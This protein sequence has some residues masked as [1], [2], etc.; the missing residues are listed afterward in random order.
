MYGTLPANRQEFDVKAD[1]PNPPLYLA[2]ALLKRLES[3]GV[4]VAGTAKVM[5]KKPQGT[6]MRTSFYVIESPQLSD[7]VY[8][9]NHI[10]N[11][12]YAEHIY[13]YLGSKS[14]ANSDVYDGAYKIKSFWK[15]RGLNTNGL[16]QYDGCGLSPMNA[17]SADFLVSLLM[18][19]K[20]EG[21]YFNEFYE[22]LPIAGMEGTVKKLLCGTKLAGKV[23]AKSGSISGTQA[24]AGY[25]EWKGETY[26][27]AVIVNNFSGARSAVVKAI[28]NLLLSV[29]S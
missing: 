17:I 16:V 14:T 12:H 7:I 9:V 13:R 3:N 27:F 2:Q 29:A 24:Y 6:S 26:A 23:R 22:S 5:D 10:S 19:E 18:Y 11:N 4:T 21:K 25:I 28:E 8:N 15:E 20:N 1:L